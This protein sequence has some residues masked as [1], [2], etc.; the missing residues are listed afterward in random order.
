MFIDLEIMLF[1]S[2]FSLK[3]RKQLILQ[4]L[5]LISSCT[6]CLDFIAQLLNDLK[7]KGMAISE[8]ILHYNLAV[9]SLLWTHQH[10]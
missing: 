5:Q 7:G 10:V 6:S 3:L 8:C 9:S 1:L 4:D 2:E